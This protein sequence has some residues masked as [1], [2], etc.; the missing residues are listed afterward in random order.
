MNIT[1]K[2][3]S[4]YAL[5]AVS[6]TL[7]TGCPPPEQGP[8][9]T[10]APTKPDRPPILMEFDAAQ[11]LF[12]N[13]KY[14]EAAEAFEA[15]YAKQAKLPSALFN[16]AVA[17]ES[18]G[19]LPA[20]MATYQKAVDTL[21]SNTE[22]LTGL[23]RTAAAL[24]KGKG[25]L[26]RINAML[27]E[28]PEDTSLL[29][30][31]ANLLRATGKYQE[32][33]KTARKIILRDQ[34]NLQAMKTIGLAYS[35]M[36]KLD[37]AETF[38]R[39][40]L[41][42]AKDDPSLLNNIALIQYRRDDHPQA[43]ETFKSNIEAIA[44]NPIAHANIGLIALR[45]RDYQRAQVEL[46]KAIDQGLK[47]CLTMKAQGYAFEGLQQGKEAIDALQQAIRLCPSDP[48]LSFDV[49][50]IYMIQLRDN[51]Q[52]KAIYT[53]YIKA[54]TGKR[55]KE[56]REALETIQQLDE[57]Q[58]MMEATPQEPPPAE[59]PT[60]S[61]GAAAPPAAD[62]GDQLPLE[63]VPADGAAQA[64]PAADGLDAP[65]ASGDGVAVQGTQQA[66]P[67]VSGGES[68]EGGEAAPADK[69]AD[70][71]A[72]DK[73]TGDEPADAAAPDGASEK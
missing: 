24:K 62:G 11:Q 1:K 42:I 68:G 23:T 18:D 66:P 54:G 33:I 19:N 52:A 59:E 49:A 29:N 44:Q 40:A 26:R 31:K 61:D 69:P 14:A 32:A 45:F 73:P 3:L 47:T 55:L 41:K 50:K 7:A 22:A 57:A 34:K 38:F 35:D 48:E 16:A 63:P 58:K 12:E 28:K 71:P 46:A 10:A 37:L 60:D 8:A 70:T 56:A 36:G 13:K 27:K 17:Y 64:A 53:D 30:M 15:V 21:P 20:A 5:A 39:N 51:A 6:L 9:V 72:A 2:N 25:A 65:A 43:L 67:Q 4:A